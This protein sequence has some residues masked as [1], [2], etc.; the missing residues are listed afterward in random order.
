MAVALAF[1]GCSSDDMIEEVTSVGGVAG[2]G[3]GISFAGVIADELEILPEEGEGTTG[4][5]RSVISGGKFAS[6]HKGDRV[7][8]SDG[9][10]SY[11]YETE[12]TTGTASKFTVREGGNEFT[13]DTESTF[14]A[15][16]PAEAV[17]SWNGE[18]VSATIYAH[19][20]YTENCDG[21]VFGAYMVSKEGLQVENSN[22]TFAFSLIASVI[23]V[24]LSTLG[25]TPASVS[26]KS[27]NGEIIAG[28]LT[29]DYKN[30]SA[31]VANTDVTYSAAST[32]SDVITV[33]N[34]A[35]DAT[36]VR[37]YVLPVQL[38]KGVTI[39]VKDTN[40]NYY[41]KSAST[42]VGSTASEGRL[43]TI[44]NIH[45]DAVVCN[46]YYKKYNFGAA[47]TATRKN[48]WMATIPSNTRFC[49]LSIPA[50]HDAATYGITSLAGIS[51][52][53]QSKT[54]AEQLAGGIRGF[55]IR[56][57][58]KGTTGSVNIDNLEISHGVT[59]N[60]LFQE[61]MNSMVDFVKDN[62]T[63]VVYVR[64]AKNE[65]PGSSDVSEEMRTAIRG[66]L[67]EKYGEGLVEGKIADGDVLD[68]YRGKLVITSDNPYGAGGTESPVYGGRLSWSDNT[69]GVEANI[70][71]DGGGRTCTAYVQDYY[72]NVNTS[73]KSPVVETVLKKSSA[74]SDNVWYLNF[75]NVA[76]IPGSYAEAINGNA[77][78][79][80]ASLTGRT[81]IVFY[82]YCLDASYNGVVL[83]TAIINQNMKYV[84][85]KRTRCAASS[86]GTV[87]GPEVKGD[88]TAD[89]SEVY[90]K[91]HTFEL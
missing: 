65:G 75:L 30:K 60:V 56:P 15:F 6:W 7:A 67:D 90:A 37:F 81:G 64:L 66:Y 40:G 47:S 35:S 85:D 18:K 8:I 51:A 16:Y 73:K 11:Q 17:K 46:P 34:I 9:M 3:E 49:M 54:I 55:D 26:L 2:N 24:N 4:G 89:D 13:D 53:T 38:S 39:T 68:K 52:K 88:E 83:N 74:A 91:D 5:T 1:A 12:E 45:S 31:K 84:Y 29:Y 14:Y 80:I 70:N 59:T 36:L 33:S 28:L 27:N 86:G 72:D 25:V 32:Q 50:A 82:D 61:A 10:L 79:V 42:S 21:G 22:V 87:D 20:D 48:N 63:E 44:K 23:E 41:T 57:N 62:P 71:H 78:T 77:N 43:T 19:Q 58:Y 69:Q 76:P